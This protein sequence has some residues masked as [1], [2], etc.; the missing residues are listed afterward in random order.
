M[1]RL[2]RRNKKFIKESNAAEWR[3]IEDQAHCEAMTHVED[4]NDD[5]QPSLIDFDQ[6]EEF[7]DPKI[8]KIVNKY[9]RIVKKRKAT[10]LEKLF[11]SWTKESC[12]NQLF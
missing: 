12:Y 8:Q 1:Q 7:N 10:R 6:E 3:V 9:L 5:S 4:R 11:G 2:E